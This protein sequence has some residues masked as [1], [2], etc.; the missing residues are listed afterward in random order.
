MNGAELRD[1]LTGIMKDISP[2]EMTLYEKK[3]NEEC[4]IYL[5]KT[6]CITL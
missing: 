2:K 1:C 5:H 4:I 6:F 3:A